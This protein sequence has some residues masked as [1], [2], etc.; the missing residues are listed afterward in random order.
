MKSNFVNYHWFVFRLKK[1]QVL[2]LIIDLILFALSLVTLFR[3]WSGIFENSLLS[4]SLAAIF[5]GSLLKFGY[6]LYRMAESIRQNFD[7]RHGELF[8]SNIDFNEVLPEPKYMEDNGFVTIEINLDGPIAKVVNSRTIDKHLAIQ[9]IALEENK[10]KGKQVFKL[11]KDNSASFLP[12]LKWQYKLSKFQGK[13][14]FNEQKL[15]LSKDLNIRKNVATCHRGSYY[16]TFL[17]NISIG[18]QLRSNRDNTVI[19]ATEAFLPLKY[20]GNEMYI[21]DITGSIINNEIGISTLAITSDNYLVIWK[22][23]RTA[24]AS[25]DLNVPTGS[26]S[27]DWNDKT[28]SNF[29]ESIKKAMK[30]E[31]WEESGGARICKKY[32]DIGDTLIL[33][34]FRWLAKCGKPEFVGLTKVKSDLISFVENKNEVYERQ[35][36]LLTGLEDL[37]LAINQIRQSGKISVPLFMNLLCLERYWDEN[38]EE[39]AKF[40]GLAPS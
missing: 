30:R 31:L 40:I 38:K 37:K 17:T 36:Y 12:F 11:I 20:L 1:S 16:E 9:D 4:W 28:G 26:G 33:G 25:N 29:S 34:Y 6:D 32:A 7:L 3:E 22:Q 14:F 23:N 35:E 13:M 10:E 21:K 19:A 18:G 8:P 27:C 39:L 15:C 2:I 24:Q 5:L